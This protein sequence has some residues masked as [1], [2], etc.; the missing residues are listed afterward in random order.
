MFVRPCCKPK[1]DEEIYSF[2][3]QYPWA[4]LVNNGEQGPFAGSHSDGRISLLIRRA[5]LSR[6][7]QGHSF[8]G[9]N[10]GSVKERR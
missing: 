4:L 8:P 3:E 6:R 10:S 1:S 9:A 5:R 2:I 7:V